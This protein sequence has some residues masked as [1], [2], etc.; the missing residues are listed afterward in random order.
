M[1]ISSRLGLVTIW[2]CTAMLARTRFSVGLAMTA[3][4]TAG[5]C[6]SVIAPHSETQPL[7]T[8]NYPHRTPCFPQPFESP[9]VSTRPL[10]IRQLCWVLLTAAGGEGEDSIYADPGDGAMDDDEFHVY[11]YDPCDWNSECSGAYG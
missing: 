7:C 4:I 10:T 3:P 1:T 9:N 6:F 8:P 2:K 11:T 5:H